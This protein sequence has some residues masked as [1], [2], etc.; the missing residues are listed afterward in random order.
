MKLLLC[1][2]GRIG[3]GVNRQLIHIDLVGGAETRGYAL[4][5]DDV[6]N[7]LLKK[8]G[9]EIVD[10]NLYPRDIHVLY[11]HVRKTLR[12]E[13]LDDLLAGVTESNTSNDKAY[14]STVPIPV[15]V[16]AVWTSSSDTN[17]PVTVTHGDTQGNT[18]SFTFTEDYTLHPCAWCRFKYWLRNKFRR[19]KA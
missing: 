7:E 15:F 5:R 4:V 14:S 11:S 8:E 17:Y 9:Y 13:S 2:T 10:P 3:V 12:K 19:N 6:A 1:P 16:P 18:I